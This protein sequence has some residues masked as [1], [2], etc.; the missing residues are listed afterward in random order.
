MPDST[1]SPTAP[2][3]IDASAWQELVALIDAG[4]P[5]AVVNFMRLLPPGDTAYTV[6]HVSPEQRTALVSML[7]AEDPEFAADLLEHLDDGL[8]AGIVAE[9]EPEEAATLVEEMDSDEQAD[10]LA[11]VPDE[12]VEAILGEMPEP[13][14]QDVRNRLR[15]E[16]DTA[17]GLMITEYLAFEQTMDV[18]EVRR[19]LRANRDRYD[20][21]EVRYLY[22]LD[23]DGRLAGVSPVRDLLLAPAGDPLADHT[24]PT[25]L[26]V[27]VDTEL[28]D[29]EDLFDRVNFA[30]VPVLDEAG[31]L[32]GVVQRAAVQEAIGEESREDLAKFGGIIRGEELRTMPVWSRGL[33]RLA[34]LAPVAGLTL[35]SAAVVAMFEDT[36]QR[37]PILAAFLPVVAGVC[38]SGGTQALAVS[39]REL[40]LGLVSIHDFRR[41]LLKEAAVAGA[42][43]VVLGLMMAVVAWVWKGNLG[44]GLAIGVAIPVAITV[45][46]CV[47]GTVPVLLRGMGIDPA[48]ASGPVVTTIADLASFL[49]TLGFAYLA[50]RWTAGG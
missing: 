50:M 6:S 40:S 15:Y 33:R 27:R 24:I 37:L 48:M 49:T 18:R 4:Q 21:Y 36:V 11:V 38:G 22:T 26:A 3:D 32:L 25:P 45:A 2:T 28:G 7:T 42:I 39:M 30:A 17:G 20:V 46:K 16:P 29:L 12:K 10:V 1:P 34:F 14:A 35:V 9:L 44:L 19:D 23:A 31:V 8:T 43:G 47:G 5:A 41:V 13:A